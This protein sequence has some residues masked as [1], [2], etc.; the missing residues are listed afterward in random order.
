MP[1][2]HRFITPAFAHL[3]S[4]KH[5]GVF[6]TVSELILVLLPAPSQ[7]HLLQPVPGLLCF[8]L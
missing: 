1:S 3:L 7:G 4:N 8:L 5:N 2:A 6:Y